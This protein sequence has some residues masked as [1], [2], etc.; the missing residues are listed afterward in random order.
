MCDQST[1]ASI[2]YSDATC[3]TETGRTQFPTNRCGSAGSQGLFFTCPTLDTPPALSNQNNDVYTDVLYIKDGGT[4]CDPTKVYQSLSYQ[5]D[6]C[7]LGENRTCA[8]SSPTSCSGATV[9]SPCGSTP[10]PLNLGSCTDKTVSGIVYESKT[11]CAGAVQ[12]T[13]PPQNPENPPGTNPSTL[14]ACSDAT[15]FDQCVGG[16]L[17][18]PSNEP[19]LPTTGLLAKCCVWCSGPSGSVCKEPGFSSKTCNCPSNSTSGNTLAGIYECAA[20]QTSVMSC[21]C[22]GR[23]FGAGECTSASGDNA[24]A[25]LKMTWAV[26]IAMIGAV[27][28]CA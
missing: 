25:S 4:P 11:K 17:I 23:P 1:L 14:A 13:M 20:G 24:G 27:L 7:V 18:P 22:A 3:M 12:A 9:A 8:C 6:L 19:T 15:T 16:S 10:L 21:A 2:F 26:L 28:V 5:T